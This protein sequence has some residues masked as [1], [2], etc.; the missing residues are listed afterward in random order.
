MAVGVLSPFG[1]TE[2]V[3]EARLCFPAVSTI[4]PMT[5]PFTLACEKE[6]VVNIKQ[7]NSIKST[8]FPI[9]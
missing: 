4:I 6:W 5:E 9:I 1:A 7:A 3:A 2:T 8:Y